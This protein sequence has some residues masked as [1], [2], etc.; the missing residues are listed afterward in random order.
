MKSSPEEKKKSPSPEEKKKSPSPEEKMKSPSPEIVPN[1]FFQNARFS[2]KAPSPERLPVSQR[3]PKSIWFFVRVSRQDGHVSLVKPLPERIKKMMHH[4]TIRP[5]HE[6]AG[7]TDYLKFDGENVIGLGAFRLNH[8]L[9]LV[10][11]VPSCEAYSD[12]DPRVEPTSLTFQPNHPSSRHGEWLPRIIVP[13][14]MGRARIPCG[15]SQ[16]KQ[17][18]S[19]DSPPIG[20]P[21]A[22]PRRSPPA[23]AVQHEHEGSPPA[24]AVRHEDSPARDRSPPYEF[25]SWPRDFATEEVR[26][27]QEKAGASSSN[28]SHSRGQLNTERQALISPLPISKFDSPEEVRKE[29]EKAG[30]SSSNASPSRGQLNTERRALISPLPIS[31]FDSPSQGHLDSERRLQASSARASSRLTSLSS[32]SGGGDSV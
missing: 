28:A 4:A 26:K 5:G 18:D 1:I 3:L 29:Q 7:P 17:L 8:S 12:Q 31:R 25:T 32:K 6:S 10:I 13:I 19:E 2:G 20:N 27:E 15:P 23:T 16:P 21:F 22:S 24:T 11:E 30:A 14:R 9:Q